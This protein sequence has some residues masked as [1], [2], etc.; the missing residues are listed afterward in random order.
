MGHHKKWS[1][2]NCP[3][4]EVGKLYHLRSHSMFVFDSKDL[5]EDFS[6]LLEP[7]DR[8]A[9]FAGAPLPSKEEVV[10]SCYRYDSRVNRVKLLDP[11]EPF[12]LIDFTK[13]PKEGLYL[14]VM[15]CDILGWARPF[16]SGDNYYYDPKNQIH[17]ILERLT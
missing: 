4:L 1:S 17:L 3:F 14:K 15:Y 10:H 16:T 11:K 2:P 6:G 7:G 12:L 8:I 9:T 13:S 5:F